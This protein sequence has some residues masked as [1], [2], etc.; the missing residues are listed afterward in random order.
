MEGIKYCDK[1]VVKSSDS[2]LKITRSR[3]GMVIAGVACC[4]R[5][6]YVKIYIIFIITIHI[7]V[8]GIKYRVVKKQGFFSKE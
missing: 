3:R 5:K 2:F 1:Q 7:I 8:V 6:M 4:A